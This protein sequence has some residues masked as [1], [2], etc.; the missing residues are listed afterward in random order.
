MF[1]LT[2]KFLQP[3]NKGNYFGICLGFYWYGKNY[4]DK[5]KMKWHKGPHDT[6][7]QKREPVEWG[8]IFANQIYDEGLIYKMHKKLI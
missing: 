5:R 8:L 1:R 3:G 4:T 7:E 2:C 6:K